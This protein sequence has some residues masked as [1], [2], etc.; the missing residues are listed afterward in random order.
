VLML[1]TLVVK[2]G[3]V[4]QPEHTMRRRQSV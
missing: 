2:R 4:S 3:G 1:P